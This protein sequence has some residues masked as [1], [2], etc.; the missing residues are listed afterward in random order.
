MSVEEVAEFDGLVPGQTTYRVYL[1]CLNE[2]DY[3]TSCSG[4]ASKP[5][6]LETTSGTW[7]NSPANTS[8]NAQGVNA[9]FYGTFPDLAADSF[10]TLG[11]VDATVSP[12]EQPSSVWGDIDPTGLFAG[13]VAGANI[14]VNDNIGGAWYIPFPGLAAAG[15]HVA[16][17]G[18]DLRICIMQITTAG[19]LSGQC[20]VQVFME[21]DQQNGEFRDVFEFDSCPIP[22]CTDE[23]AC[24]FDMDAE[25][26]DG[27]CTYVVEGECDCDGNVLDA[28]GVCGGSGIP[29]GVAT[30][31]AMFLTSVAFVVVPAFLKANATATATLWT[32]AACVAVPAFL[33][34]NATATATLWTSAA[35]VAVLAFLKG[36]ATATATLWTSAACV[37]VLAFLKGNATATATLWTS[38]A[39]VAV[40]AFLKAN[41]TATAT[42]W[43][44]A[45]CVA[46]L[47][48]LKAI[49]TATAMSWTSAA[50][51]AEM[52]LSIFC[53]FHLGVR[54]VA[55]G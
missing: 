1:N 27:S 30:A 4:D 46:V 23:T 22:G 20:Q 28:C 34:A 52:E 40:L 16:F 2:T 54:T 3:L 35:C 29:E 14:T 50:Y 25:E 17:A 19:T 44:S 48:S 12:A 7:F 51:V 39:C 37:A 49:A 5:F 42:L 10:L 31:T 26:D 43:T 21:G 11:A 6:I 18:E 45:A 32:S 8:W 9:L 24:N 36:N 55:C 41:V 53:G 13:D 47:A 38:A 33:K 15:S